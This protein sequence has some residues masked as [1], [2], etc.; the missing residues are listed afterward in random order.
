MKQYIT[1]ILILSISYSCAIK[2]SSFGNRKE[3]SHERGNLATYK[4][5]FIWTGTGEVFVKKNDYES[6]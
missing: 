2:G 3:F 4:N 1:V 6:K 5:K